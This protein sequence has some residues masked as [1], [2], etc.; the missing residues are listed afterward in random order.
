MKGIINKKKVPS[1]D[2]RKTA[3]ELYK[4]L[5]A[6]E[7]EGRAKNVFLGYAIPNFNRFFEPGQ[8]LLS[9]H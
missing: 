5:P 3:L 2:P 1:S 9:P 4:N 6:S 7:S 8:G